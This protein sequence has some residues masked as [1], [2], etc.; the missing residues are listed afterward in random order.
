MHWRFSSVRTGASSRTQ[1]GALPIGQRSAFLRPRPL[2]HSCHGAERS[3][4]GVGDGPCSSFSSVRFRLWSSPS[5]SR[6]RS[7]K[8]PPKQRPL[9]P[10]RDTQITLQP[11]HPLQPKVPLTARRSPPREPSCPRA[12]KPRHPA[13]AG[14]AAPRHAVQGRPTLDP[15]LREGF[16][17]P[18]DSQTID[19]LTLLEKNACIIRGFGHNTSSPQGLVQLISGAPSFP[20]NRAIRE[21]RWTRT[22]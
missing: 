7:L 17:T 9:S 11:L 12:A 3:L 14:V 8:E 16:I 4:P 19:V 21:T 10:Q 13:A 22:N 18:T 15:P 6:P 2:R 20:P 1:R 5:L